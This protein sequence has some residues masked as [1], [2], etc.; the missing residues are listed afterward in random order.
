MNKCLLFLILLLI[1]FLIRAQ[2]KQ[3]ALAIVIGKL[4]SVKG[5]VNMEG[6]QVW[7]PYLKKM[8]T[9]DS[10]G[11]F[12]FNN[13]AFGSY[14]L[15]IRNGTD[16]L[17]SFGIYVDTVVTNIGTIKVHYDGS[18]EA[19]L[20]NT[21]PLMDF[22]ELDNNT[23]DENLRPQNAFGF[24]SA[25]KNLYLSAAALAFTPFHYQVRGYSR[26][27]Q[28]IYLNGV[29]M[30][31][32]QTGAPFNGQ[33][34]GLNDVLRGNSTLALAPAESGFGGLSGTTYMHATAA[35]LPKQG[36]AYYT[37]SNRLYHNNVAATYSTG[38]MPNGWAFAFDISKRWTKSGYVAGTF[39][40]GYAYYFG[41][42]KKLRKASTVHFTALGSPSQ[43]GMTT[44]VTLEAINLTE[45]HYYNPNWGY[46]NG[47]KRNA[48]V[49]RSF[50]PL[51]MLNYDYAFN[52][53]TSLSL[54]A[55]YQ[56]GYYENSGLDW[57]NAPVPMPDYYKYL[58][59]YY[60]TD[61]STANPVK[62]AAVRDRWKNDASV[63][64]I[65]WNRLYEAN[66]MNLDSING[67]NGRRAAYMLGA[68]RAHTKQYNFAAN[69]QSVL[70]A[71]A[72]FYSG[73]LFTSQYTE[74]Y[75]KLLDLLG[76]DYYV[77]LNQF[78][79]QA[80]VGNNIF[81]QNNLNQPDGIVKTGDTYGYHYISRLRK[82]YGWSQLVF[83]QQLFEGFIAARAGWAGFNRE[84]MYKNGLFADDSYGNAPV[85]NYFNY[86]I[87]GGAKY[88]VNGRHYLYVNAAVMT[89]APT[90]DD[91]YISPKTRNT[92]INQ[93]SLANSSSIEAGYQMHTHG[94]SGRASGFVTNINNTR[95]IMRFY[96]EDYNAFVNYVMQH[97]NTRHLG[98][99]LALQAKVSPL[100]SVNVVAVWMQ[101]FYTSNPDISIYRDNDTSRRVDRSI[102]YLKNAYVAVGPQSAYT[103]GLNYRSHKHGYVNIS[104]NYLDRNYTALNPSR[105]TTEA[106]GNIPIGSE[107]WHN[108]VDPAKMTTAFTV[109]V[110]AG[111]SFMLHKSK[112]RL[113][114]GASVYI[115]MGVTNLLNNE[116]IQTD[117]FEQLRFDWRGLNP[118]RFP[119]KYSYGYGATYFVSM[120]LKL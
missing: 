106:I 94:L 52:S 72:H 32:L 44:T 75:K 51:F 45:S 71:H 102:A 69:F 67:M 80:Y 20:D 113:P 111:K 89:T 104:F 54:I 23:G 2:K 81:N 3:H 92:R 18:F 82:M 87:K 109:D 48:K 117:G 31:D 25:S 101:V 83:T 116:N 9:T 95:E 11:T 19:P 28:E 58:P 33:W 86:Q 99:E 34:S 1:P 84:G 36:R 47:E 115:N 15:I 118:G 7:V 41:V 40:D 4:S 100:F 50:Q 107:Q 57:Y 70:G 13:V 103:L 14:T 59:S 42:S 119:P 98:A 105:R 62:A 64:Q 21:F 112:K 85:Q 6:L 12:V 30:S 63:Q 29:Q 74:H 76:S 60:E 77:N 35:D 73:L 120:G 66:E 96:H 78:A 91:T 90:F 17:D 27:Q 46:L 5:S 53:A 26:N 56:T 38:L 61:E 10:A 22:V 114:M 39:Y 49:N 97:V 55:A 16:R 93:A 37:N 88:K 43:S 24:L 8:T 108:I 65:N 79:E 68:D 110:F